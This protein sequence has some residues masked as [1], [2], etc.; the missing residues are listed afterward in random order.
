MNKQEWDNSLLEHFSL[1]KGGF[2]LDLLMEM[3]T[4]VM[5]LDKGVTLLSEEKGEQ[6][7]RS[8]TLSMIPDIEVS[9][10]GW[11]D[12][13]TPDGEGAV[14]KS[15][16]R[17]MLEGYL[18]NIVGPGGISTLQSK[19]AQLSSLASNPEQFVNS[20]QKS[21][22]SNG[23]K[24]RNVISFL[25]FY[26]TLTKIIANFNASSAGFSFEA[27]LATLLGGT[28]IPASG[29]D[30][31]A[32]F[33]D[34]DGEKISLK[35]YNEKTVEVGGSFDAL[36]GDL[37]RDGK[38]TYLVCTK[39]LRGT[40]EM[41]NGNLKFYKFDFTLDNVMEILKTSKPASATTILLPFA[42]DSE[43]VSDI[44]APEKVKAISSEI[45][46][47][48]KQNLEQ[49]LSDLPQG[50]EIA[51][52]IAADPHFQYRTDEMQDISSGQGR[53]VKYI[54]LKQRSKKREL[55]EQ[56]LRGMPLLQDVE[57]MMPIMVAI[58]NSL[59]SVID[60]LVQ[61]RA[62]RRASVSSLTPTWSKLKLKKGEKG[63]KR[64]AK[65]LGIV[66]AAEKSAAAYAELRGQPEK[67]KALLLKT[68]GYLNDLQFS[69]NKN[70]V[71]E[72]AK[73]QKGAEDANPIE[74]VLEIGTSSLQKM[75]DSCITALNTDIFSVFSDLETLSDSLNRFFAGG[76]ADTE[77][78]SSAIRSA[79][80]IEGK[81]AE[82]TPEK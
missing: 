45:D 79:D 5:E 21:G 74:G 77:E 61:R 47:A 35:L 37:V 17:E 15:R 4:E 10:L 70:E 43:T 80:S 28:Q 22:A 50:K 52:Q 73:G 65:I 60:N 1:K 26:K 38:M 44:E 18:D 66:E 57:D 75:L 34:A 3:V 49:A 62:E 56:V 53:L 42:E 20:M 9:E 71:I 36:V 13:R 7:Q 46:E 24:I 67:Q 33:Y 41:L 64:D 78:A 81:T 69:L 19:L 30:T 25:V 40:R 14:Y 23:E 58:S 72:L 32:D 31:I 29:A 68:N 48:F 59:S 12:V 54:S 51:A 8:I 6:M 82:M 27:F 39:D 63:K 76:L 2:S 11:A 16:E 55:M